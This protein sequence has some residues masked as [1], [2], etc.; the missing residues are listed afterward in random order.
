MYGAALV[1][2][3]MQRTIKRSEMLALCMGVA[4]L[5]GAEAVFHTD[6]V[7]VVHVVIVLVGTTMMQ[8]GGSYMSKTENETK[9]E[10][11]VD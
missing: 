4:D 6:N 3:E 11:D 9:S 7:G 8:I 5:Q 10:S 2:H 1:Q